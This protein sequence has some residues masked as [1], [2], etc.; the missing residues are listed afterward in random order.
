MTAGSALGVIAVVG[1]S[2]VHTL[3]QLYPVF[4][5]IGL[6]WAASLWPAA[7]NARWEALHGDRPV[8]GDAL[9]DQADERLRRADS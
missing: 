3:W 2:R 5:L 9:L 6:A 4:V 8:C 1:W 7:H